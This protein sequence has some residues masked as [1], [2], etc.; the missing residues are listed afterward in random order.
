MKASRSA[1]RCVGQ[2]VQLIRSVSAIL[3]LGGVIVSLSSNPEYEV[4]FTAR[5]FL[6]YLTNFNQRINIKRGQ[7]SQGLHNAL[8]FAS[9]V[10]SR[11]SE[12]VEK[13][14]RSGPLNSFFFGLI[15]Q[16]MKNIL[17]QQRASFSNW[18]RNKQRETNEHLLVPVV[19][20]KMTED[21][22][23]KQWGNSI[24]FEF[25]QKCPSSVIIFEQITSVSFRE[26]TRPI[27]LQDL[28]RLQQTTIGK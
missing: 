9:G 3:M 28:P 14:G 16:L 25:L 21:D 5:H 13:M 2:P 20:I 7:M 23:P 18:E 10:S 6:Q 26:V 15:Q 12:M 22:R 27:Q 8:A 19:Q 11:K 17:H 1:Q 4:Q 24:M